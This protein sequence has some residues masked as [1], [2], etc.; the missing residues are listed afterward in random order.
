[1]YSIGNVNDAV[2]LELQSVLGYQW[3]SVSL[4]RSFIDVRGGPVQAATHEAT[5][6]FLA[7]GS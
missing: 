4:A 3:G 5:G 2:D 1:M 6:V 7:C